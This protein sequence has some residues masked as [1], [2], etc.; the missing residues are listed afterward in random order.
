LSL[1]Y[2]Y[3]IRGVVLNFRTAAWAAALL[4]LVT[5]AGAEGG[6]ERELSLCLGSALGEFR[7]S[8]T[9]GLSLNLPAGDGLRLEPEL[10]YYYDPEEPSYTPGLAVTSTGLSAGVSVLLRWEFAGGRIVLDAGIGWGILHVSETREVD[11]LREF[12]SRVSSEPYVGPAATVHFP[13][14]GRS[15]VRFDYRLLFI[16]WDGR[17]IPRLS[18][19]YALRY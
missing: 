14:D 11:V 7:S 10:F 13:L 19:G 1:S 2:A 4:L 6:G 18:L 8:F 16:P 5:A 3:Q 12:T 9:L 15:G 17:T